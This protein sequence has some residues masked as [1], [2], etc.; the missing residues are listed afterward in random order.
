MMQIGKL[1]FIQGF[2][3]SDDI[4]SRMMDKYSNI[5]SVPRAAQRIM[6]SVHAWGLID[7]SNGRK[8]LPGKEIK[9]ENLKI[10]SWQLKAVLISSESGRI[11]F[12]EIKSIPF[13]FPF[14]FELN[15]REI[16]LN[17]EMAIERD[18]MNSEYLC[19]LKKGI[20]NHF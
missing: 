14:K 19:L 3:Y 5:S 4:E 1:L 8:Y 9:I 17:S 13:L 16:Y 7:K 10:I 15:N 18:G 20:K 12:A 6:Q 2:F 11:R